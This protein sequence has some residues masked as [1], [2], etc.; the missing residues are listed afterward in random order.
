MHYRQDIAACLEEIAAGDSYEVCLTAQLV[1]GPLKDPLRL[2]V[3]YAKLTMCR[4]QGF[5]IYLGWPSPAC[6][7]SD[8]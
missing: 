2:I 5:W 1:G 4:L 3:A 8:F 6:R 7:R